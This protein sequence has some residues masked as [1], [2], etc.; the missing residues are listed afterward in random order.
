MF[1]KRE[2]QAVLTTL[3]LMT[4][5]FISGYN[6]LATDTLYLLKTNGTINSWETG[7]ASSLTWK[8]KPVRAP[9]PICPAAFRAYANGPFTFKLYADSNLV[10]TA[11]VTDTNVVRL[12]AGYKAKEFQLE[13]TGTASID[14]LAIATSIGE[15]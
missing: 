7:T 4:F 11:M 15:L 13:V 6:D 3:D 14:S 2:A 5:N 8:S 9:K 10:H 12:P 1:D